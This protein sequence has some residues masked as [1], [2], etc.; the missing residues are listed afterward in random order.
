[1]QD[2]MN[3]YYENLIK[4]M[5]EV[6]RVAYWNRKAIEALEELIKTP[7]VPHGQWL[8]N[9]C[10]WECSNCHAT[11]KGVSVYCPNCGAKM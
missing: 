2:E 9:D 4:K 1:M 10:G 3:D 8:S 7:K 6:D 5:K 11:E